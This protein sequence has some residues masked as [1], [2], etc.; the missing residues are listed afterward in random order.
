[1]ARYILLMSDAGSYDEYAP[2]DKHKWLTASVL[3]LDTFEIK[4]LNKKTLLEL[5]DEGHDIQGYFPSKKLLY[6]NRELSHWDLTDNYCILFNPKQRYKSPE[7]RDGT[8]TEIKI[9]KKG[10]GVKFTFDTPVGR[11]GYITK[12]NLTSCAEMD[13]LISIRTTSAFFNDD[14][15]VG[16][17]YLYVVKD[18]SSIV[19]KQEQIYEK[20]IDRQKRKVK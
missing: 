9:I 3:D 11:G 13:N 6:S 12:G 19:L 10:E 14:N 18:C 20:A 2:I 8:Y 17:D 7:G 16:G 5:L 4:H 15:I 1:M